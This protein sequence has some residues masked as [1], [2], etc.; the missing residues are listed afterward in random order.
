MSRDTRFPAHITVHDFQP[1]SLY[2]RFPDRHC[3]RFPAHVTRHTL[4]SSRHDILAFQPSQARAHRHTV[5]L[6]HYVRRQQDMLSDTTLLLALVP[7]YCHTHRVN[8]AS[9][10]K[11]T[12]ILPF[13]Y[14]HRHPD[15][16]T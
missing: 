1:T 10:T 12:A 6:W 7:R 5:S 14:S 8:P 11:H 2:T 15:T 16:N 4:S 13:Q 9:L 3:T